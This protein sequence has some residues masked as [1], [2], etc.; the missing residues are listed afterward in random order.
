MVEITCWFDLGGS[1][2]RLIVGFANGAATFCV[3]SVVAHCV[4]PTCDS[5]DSTYTFTNSSPSVTPDR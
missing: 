4:Q 3:K 1:G 5:G 2:A